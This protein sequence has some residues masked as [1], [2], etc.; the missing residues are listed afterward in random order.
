[1]LVYKMN[2]KLEQDR[3]V[4]GESD[5]L[6]ADDYK[7]GEKVT[8][9]CTDFL[10]RRSYTEQRTGDEKRAGYYRVED[11]RKLPKEFRLGIENE[12]ALKAKFGLRG[13][14][15]LV[16]KDVTLQVKAYPFGANGFV[17]VNVA[18]PQQG[19]PAKKSISQFMG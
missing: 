10:G 16:G 4:F 8:V 6:N 15:E 9:R 14:E 2:G 5:Y 18:L 13:Y 3:H 1:M 19:S 12:R 7:A 11:E 17:I